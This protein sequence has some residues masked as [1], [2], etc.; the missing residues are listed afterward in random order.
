MKVYAKQPLYLT[1]ADWNANAK[2]PKSIS[3]TPEMVKKKTLLDLP[4]NEFTSGLVGEGLL[5]LPRREEKKKEPKE[6][7]PPRTNRSQ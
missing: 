2:D 3:F 6:A 5:I 7:E 1:E 4:E